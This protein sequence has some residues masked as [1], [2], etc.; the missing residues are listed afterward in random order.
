MLDSAQEI[1]GL[2]EIAC[3]LRGDKLGLDHRRQR[4]LGARR[5][6]A[7]DAPAEHKLLRLREEL[8]LANAAATEFHV[9]IG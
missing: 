2:A 6:Q 4:I 8:D 9:E 3:R 7:R 1:V 5:T